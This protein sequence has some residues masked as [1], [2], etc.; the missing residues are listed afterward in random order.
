MI[1][2]MRKLTFLVYHK[3]YDAFLKDIRNLGVVHVAEKQ[4]GVSGDE[5]LQENLN[6]SK[7]L[8]ATLSQFNT[9]NAANKYI[10]NETGGSPER[11]FQVLKEVEKLQHEKI[12]L[13]Q[14]LQGYLKDEATLKPWGDFDPEGIRK[15]HDEGLNVGFYIASEH[16]YKE[17]WESLYNAVVVSRMASK[18]YF[19]TITNIGEKLDLDVEHIKAPTRSLSKVMEQIESTKQALENNAEALSNL[20]AKDVASLKAAIKELH[21]RIEFSKVKLNTEHTAGEKLMFLQG[22]IPE[23]E[24]AAVVIYLN[25]QHA[26]YEIND[27][28]VEDDVPV[29]LNNH[30]LFAWFEPICKLYML[31][32]YREMDMTPFFAPFFMVFFGLCLGDIG[33]GL[34][35]L[36][37][38]TAY[39]VFARNVGPAMKPVLSLLQVLAFSTMICGLLTGGFFGFQLYDLD[40]AISEK[41]R[42]MVSLDNNQMFELSLVLGLVQILFGMVLKIVNRIIQFGFR[43]AIETLGW[44][45]LLVSFVFATIFPEILPMTGNVHL[46]VLGVAAVMIFCYNSPGKNI[47][48]NLG[49]GLWNTY[50][51][52]TGLLGDVL[53]YIRLFALG[54]SGGILASV[55]NS[56]AAGLA[57]D[58]IIAGPVVM[59]IIFVIGHGINIFMNVLGAIVHPMRLTFVE[60]FKNAGYTGGGKEYNPFSK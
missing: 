9:L 34:F 23:A 31:P 16:K 32:K 5:G 22:W 8:A 48:V 20:A 43:Y 27:P 39:R 3:E 1:T 51:M 11:G 29:Q 55:F 30:G 40:W 6:L 26:Y 24:E 35:L 37:A 54:L 28:D 41:L 4:R 53:S 7:Q 19:V 57:P 59:V 2:K 46:I 56:L 38:V 13:E 60:F 42:N 25:R 15:L 10:V 44:V 50:N 49:L 33:Y 12:K 14:Q 47:F 58:H 17:E 18:V 52:I 21:S 45:I 36:L